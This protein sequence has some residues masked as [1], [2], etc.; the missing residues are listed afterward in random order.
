MKIYKKQKNFCSKLYKKERKKFYSKID[1]GKITDNK[2]FCKRITPFISSK[3]FSSS[4]ITLIE[5][6]AIISEDQQVAETL[7]K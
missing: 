2:T 7:S 5:N 4:R 3:A 6:E 1:T